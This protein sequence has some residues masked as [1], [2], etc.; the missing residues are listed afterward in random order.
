MDSDYVD[1]SIYQLQPNLKFGKQFNS[2][3]KK[4]SSLIEQK[5]AKELV[6]S[7]LLDGVESGVNFYKRYRNLR[8]QSSKNVNNMRSSLH[9]TRKLPELS[10]PSNR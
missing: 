2:F 6:K 1:T 8:R 5:H 4:N 9:F 7:N 10:T 3:A